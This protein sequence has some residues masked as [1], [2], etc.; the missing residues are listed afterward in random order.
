MIK[1]EYS[2]LKYYLDKLGKIVDEMN[3]IEPKKREKKHTKLRY[4]TSIDSKLTINE[5][6][7]SNLR[8]KKMNRSLDDSQPLAVKKVKQNKT[9]NKS[10]DMD[11]INTQDDDK[12]LLFDSN[13]FIT[14]KSVTIVK[15][16][17]KIKLKLNENVNSVSLLNTKLI[18]T[19]FG[20][21]M[22][23]PNLKKLKNRTQSFIS[24]S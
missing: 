19:T 10:I 3:H 15:N 2:S 17:N 1:T 16:N 22:L 14:Q 7:I 5:E 4:W 20:S 12:N 8:N 24:H 23:L 9:N 18:N 11:L 13:N 21:G 6:L